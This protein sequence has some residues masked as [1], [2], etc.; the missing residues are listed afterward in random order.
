MNVKIE[1]EERCLHRDLN[2]GPQLFPYHR[3]AVILSVF[4]L[5]GLD[6]GGNIINLKQIK[7]KNSGWQLSKV[8][9]QLR[10]TTYY[11]E[12]LNF[13]VRD[14]NGCFPLFLV[15]NQIII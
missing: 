4:E 15:A 13:R 14:G 10:S 1:L 11:N 3:E 8:P 9:P 2:P 12:G 7:I 6:D 5:T